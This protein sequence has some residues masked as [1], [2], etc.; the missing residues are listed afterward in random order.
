M[1]G[2]WLN[3]RPTNTEPLAEMDILTSICAN[4]VAVV[5]LRVA[6]DRFTQVFAAEMAAVTAR[7]SREVTTSSHV[8]MARG[9]NTTR[10]MTF[11]RNFG[12]LGKPV[13]DCGFFFDS[14]ECMSI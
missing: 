12:K 3:H 14:F 4:Q 1:G 7:T 13:V 11:L 9:Q 8:G 6:P 10:N 5:K 2:S